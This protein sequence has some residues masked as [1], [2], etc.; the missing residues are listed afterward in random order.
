MNGTKA[1][2]AIALAVV[3]KSDYFAYSTGYTYQIPLLTHATITLA[4]AG[5]CSKL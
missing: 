1:T 3:P 5:R 4:A 2:S